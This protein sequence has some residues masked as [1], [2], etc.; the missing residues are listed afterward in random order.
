MQTK[1]AL[2]YEGPA[3]ESGLMDVYEAS[4]NMIAFS[5]FVIEAAKIAYGPTVEARA[6]VAGFTKGSFVT[7]VVFNVAGASA[8][9]FSAVD[10][11]T[12][13]SMVKGS[14]ELWKHLKGNP[15]SKVEEYNNSLVVTNNHGQ[16][17]QTN[18]QSLTLVYS[19]KGSEN[20]QRFIHDALQKSGD[21]KSV[22]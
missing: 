15:P 22:V 13:W 6:E 10:A 9:V 17:H 3:V 19:E 5:E 7:D 11:K 1:F 18:I 14:L 2:R 20:A 21:R 8:T 12:L 4:A 16:I